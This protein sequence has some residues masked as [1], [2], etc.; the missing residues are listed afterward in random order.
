MLPGLALGVVVV[1]TVWKTLRTAIILYMVGMAGDTDRS[2]RRFQVD[3]ANTSQREFLVT[4]PL[5]AGPS[6]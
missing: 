3:G 4:L 5:V 6:R 2:V 1:F